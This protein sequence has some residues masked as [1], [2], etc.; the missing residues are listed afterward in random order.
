[1]KRSSHLSSRPGPGGHPIAVVNFISAS[2]RRAVK[3]ASALVLLHRACH[4]TAWSRSL[5]NQKRTR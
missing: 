5:L 2:T 3:R 1:M 4:E